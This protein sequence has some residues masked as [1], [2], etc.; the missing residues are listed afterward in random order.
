MTGADHRVWDCRVHISHPRRNEE[1]R[2]CR[3]ERGFSLLELMIVISMTVILTG[4]LLV[5]FSGVRENLNQIVCASRQR[6][7]GFGIIMYARDNKDRLPVSRMLEEYERTDLLMVAR[8]DDSDLG[9]VH[10]GWDGIGLLYWLQYCSAPECFYCPSHLGPDTLEKTDWRRDNQFPQTIY[11][12]YHYSGHLDWDD[13]TVRR[14]DTPDLVL[15]IDNLPGVGGNRVNHQT[16]INTLRVDGSVRWQ[17]DSR[18]F[19]ARQQEGEHWDPR[20]IWRRVI[21]RR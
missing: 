10:Q 4:L 17:E 19:L 5:A 21:E 20:Y 15:A 14:L 11:T 13:N 9:Q 18:E 2:R 6:Q 3:S 16:G 1:H 8:I 12:N 7:L